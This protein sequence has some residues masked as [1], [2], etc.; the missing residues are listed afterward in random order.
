MNNEMARFVAKVKGL[1]SKPKAKIEVWDYSAV[2][3]GIDRIEARIKANNNLKIVV[4]EI[5]IS[6]LSEAKGNAVRLLRVY[7]Y[8]LECESNKLCFGITDKKYRAL[9]EPEQIMSIAEAYYRQGGDVTLVTCDE[10]QTRI[11]ERKKIN[12]IYFEATPISN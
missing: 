9:P 5:V 6:R 8:L 1:W 11:A 3:T 4:P 12:Y 10:E 7:D 2:C